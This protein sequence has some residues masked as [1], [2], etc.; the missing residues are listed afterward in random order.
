M[1]WLYLLLALVALAVA[2]KTTSVAV[3]MVC[4]LAAL[5]FGLAWVL[6]LLAARVDSQTRDSTLIL[7]PAELRRLREQA[8]ARRAAAGNPPAPPAA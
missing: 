4:L 1:H 8:E 3:L 6:K 2:F 7:D 5:G